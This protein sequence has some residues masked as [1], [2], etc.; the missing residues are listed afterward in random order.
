MS[1]M[2]LYQEHNPAEPL[3]LADPKNH[4][5]PYAKVRQQL[6]WSYHRLPTKERQLMQDS[7]VN[8]ALSVPP[9]V[10]TSSKGCLDTPVV[11]F[12][13]G[14]MGAVGLPSALRLSAN[15]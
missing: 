7:I 8:V 14:G 6:D 2:D 13:A 12:T 9:K 1:T 5:G 11:I 3:N 15:K 10:A 4:F